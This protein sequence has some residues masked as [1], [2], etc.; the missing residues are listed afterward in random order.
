MER[1][2]AQNPLYANA[3]MRGRSNLTVYDR[4]NLLLNP[5]EGVVGWSYNAVRSAYYG[6]YGDRLKIIKYEDLARFPAEILETIHHELD[7]PSFKYDFGNIQQIPGVDEFD[8]HIAAPGMHRVHP[9]VKYVPLA[10]IIPPDALQH[11]HKTYPLFWEK[12]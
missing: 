12:T 3:M 9:E 2:Y 4:I 7:L 5:Q 11:I 1:V 8:L 10:P 6:S